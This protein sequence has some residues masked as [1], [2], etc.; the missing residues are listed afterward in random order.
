M[1][2]LFEHASDSEPQQSDFG[3]MNEHAWNEN[4]D[5][6]GGDS[7]SPLLSA[8]DLGCAE[9][10]NDAAALPFASLVSPARI[11]TVEKAVEERSSPAPNPDFVGSIRQAIETLSCGEDYP[12]LRT[13]AKFVGMSVRTLQ[14]RLA[15]A[16]ASHH[17]LVAQARF[18]T[19]AA[20]LERTDAKILEL[21]LD[22]GY[23]DHANFTRAFR[24][25]AGCAPR[26]YRSRRAPHEGVAE[27]SP[28]RSAGF[29]QAAPAPDLP[30]CTVCSPSRAHAAHKETRAASKVV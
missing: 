17:M 18:A 10:L 14:R 12:T 30:I 11:E 2:F 25:W 7:R 16:G 4:L 19:A 6:D 22:L 27:L 5:L 15:Q 24:R 28:P 23:S 3:I 8:P 13:T 9:A 21:A 29:G 26:D 20:V 1:T